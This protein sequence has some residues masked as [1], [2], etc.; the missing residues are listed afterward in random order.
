MIADLRWIPVLM[1]FLV[2]CEGKSTPAPP[3][4]GVAQ[5][6]SPPATEAPKDAG[7][8]PA[9]SGMTKIVPEKRV[10]IVGG[11]SLKCSNAEATIRNFLF[12]LLHSQDAGFSRKHEPAHNPMLFIDSHGLLVN[13]Q[14]IAASWHELWMEGR[15][16]E[17]TDEIHGW[18]RSFR[19]PLDEVRQNTD[20]ETLV[21][22]GFT[23]KIQRAYAFEFM[24]PGLNAPW[25]FQVKK[26]GVEWLISEITHAP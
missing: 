22:E 1:L 8:K 4:P 13:T 17:R 23:A 15:F 14:K 12:A 16:K 25:Q 19:A 24:A 5:Q 3:H 9:P 2:A 11:C 7:V 20:V 18:L 26:R 6:N 10:P 21:R